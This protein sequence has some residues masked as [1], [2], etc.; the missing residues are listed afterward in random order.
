MAIAAL[1]LLSAIVALFASVRQA[2]LAAQGGADPFASSELP[3]RAALLDEKRAL[4]RAIKDLE[5]EHA[6]GKITDADFERLDQ[7]FRQ[8]AKTVIAELDADLAPYQARAEALVAEAMSAS[9]E[10]TPAPEREPEEPSEE[11]SEEPSEEALR[12]KAKALREEAERLERLLESKP[13]TT[14]ET[15]ED[16][17]GAS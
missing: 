10:K 11:A 6:V 15:P 17:G 16:E 4:L 7:G 3:D 5:Y 13:E 12:A 1:G 9:P 2:A 8:R 14:P